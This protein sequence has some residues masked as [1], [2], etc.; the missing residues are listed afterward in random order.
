MR[1]IFAS[2][3]ITIPAGALLS[4]VFFYIL[5]TIVFMNLPPVADAAAT[6]V[7]G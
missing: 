7:G 6:V 5:K 1:D 4:V 3:A 2:W